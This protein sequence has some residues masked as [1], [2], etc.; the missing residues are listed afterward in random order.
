MKLPDAI[1][2]LND[3]AYLTRRKLENENGEQRGAVVMWRTKGA[4]EF[5]YLLQC[6]FCGVEEQSQAFFKK[7]PYRVQCSNCGKSI[8]IEKLAPK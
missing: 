1:K 5:N 3:L 2:N 6:P 8:L 7:R 4:E